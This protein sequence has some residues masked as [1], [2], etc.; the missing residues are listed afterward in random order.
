MSIR[1]T[2]VPIRYTAV[3]IR[4]TAMSIRSSYFCLTFFP[5]ELS[6]RFYLIS[7]VDVNFANNDMFLERYHSLTAR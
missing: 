4:Y 7:L 5:N 3:P 6:L 1:F 2:A